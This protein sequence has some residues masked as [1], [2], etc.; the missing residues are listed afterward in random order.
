MFG[1]LTVTFLLRA[2]TYNT[3]CVCIIVKLL[4]AKLYCML[5]IF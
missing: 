2:P 3:Y 4:A 5:G 1:S